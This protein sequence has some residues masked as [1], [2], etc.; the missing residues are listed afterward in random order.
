MSHIFEKRC[1]ARQNEIRAGSKLDYAT[2]I[3]Y[4]RQPRSCA[5]VV[6]VAGYKDLRARCLS[7]RFSPWSSPA[8]GRIAGRGP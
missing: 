8:K 5:G 3:E 1:E 6:H 2:C 4:I 7:R